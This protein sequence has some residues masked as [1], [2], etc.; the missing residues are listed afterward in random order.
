MLWAWL[1]FCLPLLAYHFICQDW[2]KKLTFIYSLDT[3]WYSVRN[4]DVTWF[5]FYFKYQCRSTDLY[6]SVAQEHLRSLPDTTAV[7]RE[8]N[9]GP[10]DWKTHAL[11]TAPRPLPICQ[12]WNLSLLFK[13]GL[14]MIP[15]F[16]LVVRWLQVI[17]ACSFNEFH[18]MKKFIVRKIDQ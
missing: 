16:F 2:K 1:E 8:S 6:T 10:L 7:R 18:A 4:L 11:P 13:L 15:F 3:L 5:F 14:N 17:I 12:D 9:T